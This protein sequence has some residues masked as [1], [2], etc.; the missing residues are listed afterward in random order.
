MIFVHLT[1]FATDKPSYRAKNDGFSSKEAGLIRFLIRF[2]GCPGFVVPVFDSGSAQILFK[3]CEFW[4]DA[5]LAGFG[6]VS[7][8]F[9]QP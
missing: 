3:V 2:L 9:R 4:K 5:T 6:T 8:L 1:L 7:V